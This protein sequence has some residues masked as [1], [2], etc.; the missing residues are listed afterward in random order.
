MWRTAV[1]AS[2]LL[3]PVASEITS[4]SVVTVALTA[5]TVLYVLS[6]AVRLRGGQVPLM[7]WFT[8]RMRNDSEGARFIVSPLCLAVGIILSLALFPAD[9]AYASIS[10]VAVGDPAAYYAGE[11]FGRVTVRGKTLEGFAAGLVASF[12]IASLWV[13]PSLSL[14]GSLSGM[15]LELAGILNDN[16]TVPIGAGSM[17]LLVSII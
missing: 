8:M 15:L 9:I 13:S 3:V 5:V 7:T 14:V 12:L 2:A 10:V 6:E 11:R 1:H 17:M 4:K 16:L